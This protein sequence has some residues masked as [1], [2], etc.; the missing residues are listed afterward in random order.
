MYCRW[1]IYKLPVI[2][3]NIY[4]DN[5][6]CSTTPESNIF[7][8]FIFFNIHP[9]YFPFIKNIQKMVTILIIEPTNDYDLMGPFLKKKNMARFGEKGQK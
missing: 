8:F 9:Q 4:W 3:F 1:T 5:L 2:L 6:D 7:Q